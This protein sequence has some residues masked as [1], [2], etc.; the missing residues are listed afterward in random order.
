M[1]RLAS[2]SIY[3]C[4]NQQ[5]VNKVITYSPTNLPLLSIMLIKVRSLEALKIDLVWSVSRGP[6]LSPCIPAD[7]HRLITGSPG[8]RRLSSRDR[9]LITT[10]WFHT[11]GI[12]DDRTLPVWPPLFLSFDGVKIKTASEVF[13]IESEEGERGVGW[14]WYSA[15][16]R[17]RKGSSLSTGQE[18]YFPHQDVSCDTQ[19]LSKSATFRAEQQL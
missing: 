16:V 17:V 7:L 13:T 5:I 1:E 12:R 15:G 6:I 11:L 18:L 10:L 9:F 4:H 19:T 2:L 14:G 8:F 3:L